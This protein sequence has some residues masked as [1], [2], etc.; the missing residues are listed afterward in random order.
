MAQDVVHDI[1]DQYHH[2]FRILCEEVQR[3]GGGWWELADDRPPGQAQVLAYAGELEAR[4]E[5]EMSGLEDAAL[6][7]PFVQEEGPKQTRLG[8]YVYALRHMVHHHGQLAALG[9]FHGLEG[10]AWD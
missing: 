10:G 6:A 5:Q 2:T 3:F 8:H 1:V 9:V 7:E 4:I